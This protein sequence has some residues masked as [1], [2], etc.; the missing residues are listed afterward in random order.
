MLTEKQILFTLDN[1]RN[2][3]DP[4][5]VE[6]GHP[7]VYPID[8]RINVFSNKTDKWA[9]AIETLGYNPRS[10][11]IGLDIT[12]YGNCL[13]NLEKIEDQTSNSYCILPIDAS[14]FSDTIEYEKLKTDAKFWMVRNEKVMISHSKEDYEKEGIIL[15][16]YE[17]NEISAEEVARL[18]VTK[19]RELFR[20]TNE[21]LYK[22][23]P[24]DLEKIMVIDEWH[25]RDFYLNNFDPIENLPFHVP[26]SE[27]FKEAFNNQS[28]K[29]PGLVFLKDDLQ[30]SLNESYERGKQNDKNEWEN[31]SPGSYETWQLIAKVIVTGD[32]TFY[33]PKLEPTSH[34]KYWEEAGTM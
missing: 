16:E 28:D 30:A 25:H 32:P 1:Y 14:S 8:S 29:I 20:A 24:A 3:N 5:F 12:Y 13:T 22:S 2:G 18:L 27:Q 7:Y 34:W 4:I 17:P 33:N 21:E 6:L 23:I 11:P 19:H 15:K 31:N 26:T 9:I 10:E